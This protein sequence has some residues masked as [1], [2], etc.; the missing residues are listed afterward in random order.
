MAK[1]TKISWAH[2]TFNPWIGCEKVSPACDHCYAELVAKRMGRDLWG[3]SAARFFTGEAYWNEARR[4]NEEAGRRGGPWR[5]FCGSL[6]DVME[7]RRDLDERREMLWELIGETPN[8]TWLLLTKRPENF[9]KFTPEEWSGGW[10]ENV[11]ALTTVENQRRLE[12]RVPHLLRVPARVRGLSIEPMLGPITLPETVLPCTNCKG[13]GWVLPFFSANHGVP[14]KKCQERAVALDGGARVGPRTK[15]VFDTIQWV[16][17]GG[18]SGG[19]A[20]PMN[21]SWAR[22][23]RDQCAKHGVAF[24]FKQHGEWVARADATGVDGKRTVWLSTDGEVRED[25]ERVDRTKWTLMVRAGN[26][27]IGRALDGRLWDQTPQS[28]VVPL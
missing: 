28:M 24:H 6:C 4:W 11:W 20:R 10:P 16:I 8:L 2:S 3:K 21:P 22:A 12:E 19:G 18:E 26:K 13:R 27:A 17:V 23:L 15:I 9:V 5:V 7:D 14:C 1:A 25:L